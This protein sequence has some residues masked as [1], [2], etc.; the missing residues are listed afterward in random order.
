V[1]S[2]AV[3]ALDYRTCRLVGYTL[4]SGNARLLFTRDRRPIME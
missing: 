2:G 4:N 1:L 3:P